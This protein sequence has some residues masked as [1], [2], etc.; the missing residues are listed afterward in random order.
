MTYTAPHASG[1]QK[2]SVAVSGGKHIYNSPFVTLISP[3]DAYPP[4]CEVAGAG[5][6]P[7]LIHTHTHTHTHMYSILLQCVCVCVRV[8]V[9]E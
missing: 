2:I 6:L 5:L 9:R 7:T 8:R 3:G 4:N 1:L